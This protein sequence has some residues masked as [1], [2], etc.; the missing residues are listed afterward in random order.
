MRARNIKPGFYKNA[1]LSE[2][3][4]WARHLA[5]GL[6]M[7][8]DKAGRLEDRPKQIKG[9]I[10]PYD[11]VDTNSLLDELALHHHIIRYEVD[12][13]R[14]IQICK[15]KEH[16]RPHSNEVESSLPEP[17]PQPTASAAHQG[18]K[19]CSPRKKALRSD[20]L[21]PD[22][23]YLIAEPLPNGNSACAPEEPEKIN[24]ET[25][26]VD[27]NAEW[28][29]KKRSEGRYMHHDEHFVLE[30]FKQYCRSKGVKYKDYVDAYRNAFEW[31]RCQPKFSGAGGNPT[32]SDRAKD[33]IVRGLQQAQA[34]NARGP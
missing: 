29:A 32:K 4:I 9:E 2:C 20:S 24:L 7:L 33:A 26:A 21:I 16:Q 17:Q 30:Q 1:D 27:H 19:R 25:L 34:A 14:Y 8:A 13:K 31:E 28:L 11:D 18:K 12:G 6:W 3:S 23:G 22:T 10:F 15:F 5:P